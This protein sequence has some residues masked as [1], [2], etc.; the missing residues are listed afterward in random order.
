MIGGGASLRKDLNVLRI[1]AYKRD[2]VGVGLGV[3]NDQHR[4]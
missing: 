1:G 3:S 4:F 2:D